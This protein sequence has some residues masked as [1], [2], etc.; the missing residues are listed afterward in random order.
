[1][2]RLL[3]AAL[4]CLGLMVFCAAPASAD[5]GFE[6]LDV[7]FTNEDGSAA[8]QAGSHPFEMTTSFELNKLLPPGPE[9]LP[10]EELKDLFASQIAGLVGN[11]SAT[12]R[13]STVD[14]LTIIPAQRNSSCPSAT[15]VGAVA[16]NV[17]GGFYS[18]V[19]NL[20]PSPGM[21]AK[22]GFVVFTGVAVTVE[23]G[24]NEDSPNNIVARLSN[25]SQ[26][27]PVLGAVLR[28]WGN[29]AAAAHDPYRGFCLEQ[30]T[31]EQTEY[32]D[33]PTRGNCP[34][35]IPE[36]PFL[37]LP[38]ACAGPLESGFEIDSWQ[39]PG[40]WVAAKAT[41]H[42]DS[43]APQGF[44]GCSKLGFSPTIEARPSAARA[45][46]AAGLEFNLDVK[47]EGLTSPKP[48]ATAQS[49][50]KKVVAT[51]PAG[52]TVNP[53]SAAG[54]G[55]CSAADLDR[56]SPTSAP[57]AGCPQS[58]KLGTVRVDTPLLE[59][60]PLEGSVYLATPFQN[61]FN[62]LIALYVVIKSPEL[63]I[64][65]KLPGKVESD[66][67]TG[68]LTTTFDNNPQLPFSH[69][70][71]RLREGPRAPLITPRT[72]GT[73]TTE[74]ELTPYAGTQAVRESS[75]FQ[76]TSG[77]GGSPCPPASP[78]PFDPAFSAGSTN[79]NAS[80]YS[81]FDLRITR[82]DGEQAITRFDSVLPPGVVG[83]IAGLERCSEAAITTAA[84]KSGAQELAQSSCPAGSQIGSV[85]AGAGVGSELTYVPGKIYL[86]GPFGGDTLSVVVITPALAGPFDLG[87][88]VIREALAL[89]PSSAQ[90]EVDGGASAPIPQILAGVPLNLKDLRV[91][92]DRPNFTLNSTSCNPTSVIAAIFGAYADPLSPADDV[93]ASRSARYQ[94]ANCARLGFAPKLALSLKG[95]VKRSGHPALTSVLT[96]PYPSGPGYAN[97]GRAVV[98]LPRSLQIDN[99][100]V[101]NPCTR[102]QFAAKACPKNSIL[103]TARAFSPLLDEPLEGP[104]YFRSNGGERLL[105]DVVA[106]LNGLFHIVLVG[107]VDTL[108]PKTNPRLRTTFA[109]VPD[110]PVSKFVLKLKGGKE[111]LLTSNRNLCAFPRRSQIR[112]TG[113]NGAPHNTSPQV[114]V[115]CGAKKSA[116]ARR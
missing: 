96:Y 32:P 107:G 101:N 44:T 5:F 51:L 16:A 116:K 7:T 15:A 41:T 72:C 108:T 83:K 47:D 33:L 111:G 90:V 109:G 103:G 98:V 10:D 58:A 63:G 27:V 65:V 31:S 22:L 102:V 97:I 92:I 89:N 38:R 2:R 67:Q 113:Q 53:S 28:L 29:P 60:Q 49:D 6:D 84:Q 106:D 34:V 79:N 69:F 70:S 46:S 73:Y 50:I 19:Y 36:K 75:S 8:T 23:V 64:V 81:P 76:I 1:M 62:S 24:V 74:V 82:G 11:P 4:A 95:S 25:T 52:L 54:L 80:A 30:T 105:P 112:L 14:F 3:A 39:N 115:S 61:P 78:P 43:G 88:V 9:K 13:C 99:A 26:P 35:T 17:A 40:S 114:K 66:P 86:A 100:H 85:L 48:T 77:P 56:E 59:N 18:P 21:A 45:S 110:A 37:T 20:N 12:P 68:R 87:T 71:L 57:G 55:A 91:H 104:V 93:A 94:A 42:D